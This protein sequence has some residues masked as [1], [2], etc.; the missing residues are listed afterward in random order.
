[1]TLDSLYL[2]SFQ[3]TFDGM[4]ADDDKN[5]RFVVGMVVLAVNPLPPSAIATLVNLEKQ[6]VMDLLR[7]I[8]SLLKL[9]EDPDT[10]VLPFHKSFPDFI[11]DPHRCPNERF[12][13]KWNRGC[14]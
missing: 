12:H 11:T 13:G 9:N 1:V 10:P 7:L 2:S 6:E 8:Q 4:D 3:D 14:S 5:V